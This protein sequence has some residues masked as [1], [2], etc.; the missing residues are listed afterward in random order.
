MSTLANAVAKNGKALL[1]LRR[2]QLRG[3]QGDGRKCWQNH[4]Q[5]LPISVHYVCI[6]KSIWVPICII[7]ANW[8]PPR[9]S[10][11]N[12]LPFPQISAACPACTFAAKARST[13]LFRLSL[14]SDACTPGQTR[15]KCRRSPFTA[16]KL[17]YRP[18]FTEKS[19]I[20]ASVTLVETSHGR[21]VHDIRARHTDR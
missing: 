8:A 3:L 12:V 5:L 7:W 18:L 9:P 14:R 6:Y 1:Q 21:C 2:L 10:S 11:S 4:G 16:R 15:C 13:R 19:L 17:S 20:T